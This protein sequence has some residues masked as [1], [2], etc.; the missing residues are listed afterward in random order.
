MASAGKL[1]NETR[2][3]GLFVGR[4]GNGKTVAECSFP[5]PIKVY[6]LVMPQLIYTVYN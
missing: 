3:V 4:S 1:S 5:G 6:D 2:F